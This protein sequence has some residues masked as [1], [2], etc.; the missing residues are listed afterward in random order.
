MANKEPTPVAQFI[1]ARG[2]DAAVA[3]KLGLTEGAVK[4][5]KHRKRLPKTKYLELLE[6]FPGTTVEDLKKVEAA[7]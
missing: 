6:A 2:G 7:A 5:W 3:D 4:M 1:D